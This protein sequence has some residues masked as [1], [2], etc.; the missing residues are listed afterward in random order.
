ML[1]DDV[2]ATLHAINLEPVAIQSILDMLEESATEVQGGIFDNVPAGRFGGSDAGA[3]L[4]ADTMAARQKVR[5][6]MEDM[7]AGLRGYSHNISTYVADQFRNDDDSEV[8]LKS[9]L[10]ALDA[11][12]TC[13]GAPKV[14]TPSTCGLDAD[15]T[16]GGS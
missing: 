8:A 2:S 4:A 10:S 9:K 12:T 13:V 11:S 1:L 16:Q 3:A 7:V 14:S 6:A 15:G 5:E